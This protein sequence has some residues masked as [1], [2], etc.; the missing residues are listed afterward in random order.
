MSKRIKK[1]P[2]AAAASL[3]RCAKR[4]YKHYLAS[5]GDVL[6][7]L[8]SDVSPLPGVRYSVE[9]RTSITPSITPSA[10]FVFKTSRTF[11]KDKPTAVPAVLAEMFLSESPVERYAEEAAA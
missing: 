5:N 8:K 1:K 4:W 3:R 7:I 2:T 11:Y 10:R 9:V 6:L